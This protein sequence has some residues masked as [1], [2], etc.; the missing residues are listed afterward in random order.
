MGEKDKEMLGAFEAISAAT[1]EGDWRL[2]LV[3]LCALANSPQLR[4]WELARRSGLQ[5]QKAELVSRLQKFNGELPDFLASPALGLPLLMAFDELATC[6]SGAD[7][8]TRPILTHTGA[9]YWAIPTGCAQPRRCAQSR[10]AANLTHWLAHHSI[11]PQRL[12]SIRVEVHTP[13]GDLATRLTALA[14]QRSHFTIWVGHFDDESAV[15]WDAARRADGFYVAQ[16]IE[17]PTERVQSL[18]S[19]MDASWQAGAH[20]LVLPE[21][22]VTPAQRR[23]LSRRL[24]LQAQGAPLLCVP[25]SFHE[26]EGGRL[27][28]CAP[29]IDGTT[30][31]PLFTHRKLRPYGNSAEE[32]LNEG[33]EAID[34]GNTVHLLVTDAGSFT[35]LICKDHLDSHVDV[36]TLVQQLAPHWV[37][38]PSYG[39]EKTIKAHQERA[40]R[41]CKVEVGCHVAVANIRNAGI[42]DGPPLPGFGHAAGT[43]FSQHVAST[44]GL[45]DFEMPV[46]LQSPPNLKLAKQETKSP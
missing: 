28:N 18:E 11:V 33:S 43:S 41:L 38:V 10:Q 17:P 31:H 21:L 39:N 7:R 15:R 35:V 16:S 44:G 46:R 4:S 19:T 37:F 5:Q 8:L 13:R 20:A 29:L 25:G 45:L 36:A 32:G 14:Q 6:S 9:S 22:A 40:E 26:S 27:F 3:E 23:A 30:G 2:A 42:D 34:L 12:G 24:G 1:A